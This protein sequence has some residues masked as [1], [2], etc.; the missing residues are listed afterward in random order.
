MTTI[1]SS[2]NYPNSAFMSV[3]IGNKLIDEDI[4]IIKEPDISECRSN[5]DGN[6]TTT[7]QGKKFLKEII[8]SYAD[9]KDENKVYDAKVAVIR[10]DPV[11]S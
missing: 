2:S 5:S 4:I 7:E 6:K 11:A 10:N 9:Y 1:N 8:S 3:D